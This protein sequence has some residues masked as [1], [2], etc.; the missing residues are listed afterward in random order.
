MKFQTLDSSLL[1][2]NTQMC[3]ASVCINSCMFGQSYKMSQC[4]HVSQ[5]LHPWRACSSQWR[6]SWKLTWSSVVHVGHGSVCIF[7][8]LV[9][10]SQSLE[11]LFVTEAW[12]KVLVVL[13]SAGVSH[14]TSS[15]LHLAIRRIT[16]Q[17]Q[18]FPPGVRAGDSNISEWESARK[19]AVVHLFLSKNLFRQET[20][21]LL[22]TFLLWGVKKQTSKSVKPEIWREVAD[23]V[24]LWN[25]LFF[26][27]QWAIL[28]PNPLFTVTTEFPA[29][30]RDFLCKNPIRLSLIIQKKVIGSKYNTSLQ[31][32]PNRLALKGKN[33][34]LEHR[35]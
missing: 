19:Y 8:L 15:V 20:P 14:Y 33:A 28:E 29:R 35:W 26:L 32:H 24:C 4:L 31:I 7:S 30:K 17:M 12:L 2:H 13:C 3:L 1:T 34:H 23:V 6:R 27:F 9:C 10:T 16:A 11:L 5:R 18:P 21:P 22:Y 25:S